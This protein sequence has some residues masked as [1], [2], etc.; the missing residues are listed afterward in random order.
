MLNVKQPFS[1]ID[2]LKNSVNLTME[3]VTKAESYAAGV[4]VQCT[5]VPLFQ[6]K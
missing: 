5:E 4:T 3:V 1:V 6:T 2:C